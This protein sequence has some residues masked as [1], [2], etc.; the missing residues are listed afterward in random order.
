M[1]MVFAMDWF[2][3]EIVALVG[4]AT[5]LLLG[6]ISFDQ[7]FS[8]L[9]NPAVITVLEILLIVEVL[10]SSRLLDGVGNYLSRQFK[11][12]HSITLVLCVIGALL[13]TVMNN[14]GAFSLMLPAVFSISRRYHIPQRIMIMPLSFATLVGGM[15]TVVGTPPN[16]VVSEALQ[17]ATGRGFLF[18]DFL[19]TG[20]AI[21]VIGLILLASWAPRILAPDNGAEPEAEDVG[22]RMVTEVFCPMA[23]KMEITAGAVE[24]MI[25]GR[26]C[27]ILRANRRVFPQKEETKL[28]PIDCLLIEADEALLR[29]AFS[30]G[31]LKPARSCST[32][33]DPVQVQAAILPFSILQGSVVSNI[34]EFSEN[35]INVIGV[36]TQN[37]RLEG[38]LDEFRLSVGDILHIEGKIEAIQGAMANTG[39]VT[40]IASKGLFAAKKHTIWAFVI[41]LAGLIAAAFANIPPEIAYGFVL[42]CYL[43]G[44]MLDLRETLS[45][46]NWP[47]IILL[48]AMLPLGQAVA[49][50]GAATTI[51]NGL[52]ATLP[53]ASGWLL[54]LMMLVLAVSITPFVNNATTAVILAPIALEL[55]RT[56]QLPPSMLLMTVAIGASCDF[57]TPFGHHNNTLA[58]ALGPYRFREFFLVGWP[59]TLTTILV[60][61]G[62]CLYIW[63]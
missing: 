21:A 7:A 15:C 32:L 50:T 38:S 37:P 14:I 61:T 10:K 4:L 40:V 16:L 34:G 35:G 57:L 24:T 44:G 20:L 62:T 55:A 6:L 39:L 3:I 51:A 26:I 33:A 29:E 41:F 1:L 9:A 8:G 28:E 56:A 19:P 11:Q 17:E 18:L 5:A 47:I 52:L 25:D 45:R 12:P 58:Y 48:V 49:N 2:R 59:I 22:H 63:G 43:V 54:T 53:E 30:D 27:S 36:A 60:G 42:I 46:M 23:G 13:S 31:S